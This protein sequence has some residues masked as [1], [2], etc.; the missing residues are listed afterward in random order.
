MNREERF[1]YPD[2]R[3]GWFLTS[4]YPLRDTAGRLLALIAIARDV[5]DMRRAADELADARM[6]LS[7]HLENSL[8][9]VAEMDASSRIT[10][11]AGRAEKMFGWTS[12]EALGRTLAELVA[13]HPDETAFTAETFGRLDRGDEDHNTLRCRNLTKDGR[14][15]H[16]LW[17]NSVLRNPDGSVRSYL[18]LAEEITYTVETLEKLQA[19]DRLLNTLIHAT[20]T[21][22]VQLDTAGRIVALNE[23]FLSFVGA[24]E[25]SELVG[26][27]IWISSAPAPRLATQTLAKL[28]VEGRIQNVEMDMAG[29]D[30]RVATFE[31]NAN[32]E[33]TGDGIRGE[34]ISGTSPNAGARRRSAAPSRRSSR[35]RKSSR[36]SACSPAAS[37]TTSTTCS[38]AILGNAGLAAHGIARRE[39]PARETS[40]RSRWRRS[41]PPSSAGRCSPTPARAASSSSASTSTQP[42]R[43]DDAAAASLDHQERR[44]GLRVR[45]GRCLPVR[46]RRTTQLRQVVMNLV[47]NASEAIGGR[48]RHHHD[49]DRRHVRRPGVLS[50]TYCPPDMRGGRLRLPRGAATPAAAWTP[51]PRPRFSTRSSRRSSPAAGSVSRRCSASC[52]AT[53]AQSGRRAQPGTGTRFRVLLPVTGGDR[54]AACHAGPPPTSGAATGSSSWWMTR[55]RCAMSP[56]A[57][58]NTLG[59]QTITRD[60][61]ARG[62]GAVWRARTTCGSYCSI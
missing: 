17:W 55:T 9:L 35:S 20:N 60:Q 7:Q 58:C 57:C 24:E 22:Y 5:T 16:C 25:P 18:R 11:W 19:S 21:G 4:K 1:Q 44:P 33:N 36:A 61:W 30:G 31:F 53:G 29:A 40:K 6:R 15:I 14:V 50:E 48:R 27:T 23:K 13:I 56:R 41:V 59:F 42:G 49:H 52:A 28:P 45:A 46:R 39:S 51:R 54:R 2:G 43:R 47:I 32:A 8:L 26:A 37:R 10:R 12:R 3:A 38:S 62:T 34:D